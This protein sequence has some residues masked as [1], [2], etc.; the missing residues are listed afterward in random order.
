MMNYL[1]DALSK[2][3]LPKEELDYEPSRPSPDTLT[4]PNGAASVVIGPVLTP[5]VSDSS[6]SA[7]RQTLAGFSHGAAGGRLALD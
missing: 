6:A 5:T 2:S 4:P 7:S 1:M 3:G